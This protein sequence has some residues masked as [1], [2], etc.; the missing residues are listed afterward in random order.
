M[1]LL[2]QS[3]SEVVEL[4]RCQKKQFKLHQGSLEWIRSCPSFFTMLYIKLKTFPCE[5]DTRAVIQRIFTT[6]LFDAGLCALYASKQ[7]HSPFSYKFT[8]SFHSPALETCLGVK[9]NEKLETA[10]SQ[11][12]LHASLF[13]PCVASMYCFS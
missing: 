4:Y 1:D 13:S 7:Q 2:W 11:G 5:K 9:G 12:N 3:V 10:L 6:P 8:L